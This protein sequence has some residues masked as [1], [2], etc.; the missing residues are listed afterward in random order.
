MTPIFH[1]PYQNSDF[2]QLIFLKRKCGPK[3][4]SAMALVQEKKKKNS[5]DKDLGLKICVRIQIVCSERYVQCSMASPLKKTETPH[6]RL[7]CHS[8]FKPAKG[9]G[10]SLLP[11]VYFAGSNSISEG[12]KRGSFQNRFQLYLC[13]AEERKKH[14][15]TLFSSGWWMGRQ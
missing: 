11:L 1:L 14:S 7:Y 2:P 8:L 15:F 12:E 5:Y 10:L 13:K 3:L 9:I 4:I 6:K